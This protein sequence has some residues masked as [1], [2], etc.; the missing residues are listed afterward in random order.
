MGCVVLGSVELWMSLGDQHPRLD[1]VVV[2]QWTVVC[3]HPPTFLFSLMINSPQVCIC[4]Y[5]SHCKSTTIAS[6]LTFSL[7]LFF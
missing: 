7:F 4:S 3:S 2:G 5:H 1:L 6:F